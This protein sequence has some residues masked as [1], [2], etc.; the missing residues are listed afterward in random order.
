MTR[1][2]YEDEREAVRAM[3][4]ESGKSI[5]ECAMHLWGPRLKPE[6]AAAKLRSQ[7]DSHND[8]EHLKFVDVIALMQFCQCYDPLFYACMETDHGHPPRIAPK[9]QETEVIETLRSAAETMT[10]AMA[11]LEA[12]QVRQADP[13]KISAI[14]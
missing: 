3:I 4:G 1:L 8:T 14:R 2:F 5:K 9:D 10:K 12:L 13:T 6:V 11:R 7:L